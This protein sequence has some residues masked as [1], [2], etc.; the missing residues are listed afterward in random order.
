M[1]I[2]G[3]IFAFLAKTPLLTSLEA[4]L[5]AA[6][7]FVLIDITK[8]GSYAMGDIIAAGAIGTFTGIKEIVIISIFAIILGKLI[9][10]VGGKL[11]GVCDKS[12]VKEFHFAF[13]P[14]LFLI[15]AIIFMVLK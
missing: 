5:I 9:F 1:I 14:V 8:L 10:Y 12:K 13:V 11:N 2:S 3:L 15:T 4:L 6:G 7:I